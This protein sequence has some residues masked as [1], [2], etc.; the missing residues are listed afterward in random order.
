MFGSASNS[1]SCIATTTASVATAHTSS[2]RAAASQDVPTAPHSPWQ[3]PFVERFIGTLR[4]E[5]LDHVIPLSE[6]HLERLLCEFIHDYY[7]TERP[8]QGLAGETPLPRDA[9][10]P[11]TPGHTRLVATPV[12]E[13]LHHTYR[14]ISA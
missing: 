4:R 8:H 13:G 10:L 14:R 2:L 11:G 12:L 6:R 1:G 5:L 3:N 7:H 9:P